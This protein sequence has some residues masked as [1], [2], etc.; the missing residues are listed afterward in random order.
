VKQIAVVEKDEIMEI[1]RRA[2]VLSIKVL[3]RK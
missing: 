1:K 3:K 2:P